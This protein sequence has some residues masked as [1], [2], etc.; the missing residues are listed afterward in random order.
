MQFI[1]RPEARCS[2]IFLSDYDMILTEHLVQGVDLWINTPRRPWEACGTSG[3]KVLVNGGLNFS[4]LDGWWAE[5]YVPEVGW[6]LGDRKEHGD[7]PNWDREEANTLYD[8]LEREVIPEFYTRDATN[9]PVAWTTRIRESMARLT[10]HFS[11]NRAVREYTEKFY[12]PA[13]ESYHKRAE[14]N[15]ALARQIVDWQRSLEQNWG[16]L[17]FGELKITTDNDK[18]L[19]VVQVYINALN[20][21]AIKV[22]LYSATMTKQMEYQEQIPNTTDGHIYRSS[23]PVTYPASNFTPR[24]VPYFPG[25]AIPIESPQILWQG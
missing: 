18:H 7:D 22:E 1:A 25:V 13:A 8:L 24:I 16:K 10:P 4:E 15:G 3:M 17:R 5:A 23:V 20:R 19:F 21:Q 12:L 2:V 14:N 9:I 6:A 11:S